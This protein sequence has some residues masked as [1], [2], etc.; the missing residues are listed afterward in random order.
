MPSTYTA[1]LRLTLPATGELSGLWGGTVNTGVTT[2]TDAAIAGYISV[3][4][5]DAD[6]TL[7]SVN[8]ATDQARY[9]MINMTGTLTGAKNVICPAA[10][11]VYLFKNS[12][13]GGFAITLKTPSGAGISVPN[14]KS[15][16]L[17]CDGTS[18]LD[19]VTHFNA[20]T[21]LSPT[22]TTPVLGTPSS[23]TLTSCTGLPIS[24][25]VS[26]LGTGVAT[27]LATP[28]TANLA[29]AVTGETGTGALVFGTSPA[30]TTPSLSAETYSTSATVTAGTNAQG[31]GALTSDYNV[32]TT[33]AA[34]PSGVTL[35]T[36]TV[37]R[38]VVIVNRGTNT[39]NVYPA[40]SAAIDG[41]AVN[42]AISIAVNGRVEFNAA[43]TT[44]WYSTVAVGTVS[45]T[46]V[47]TANGFVGSVANPTS[48]PAI[49]LS[50]NVTGV[51]KGN[52]TA[53]SAAVSGTDYFVPGTALSA[54]S[55]NGGQ[56][57]GLRNLIING[58]MR[59]AQRGT[60]GALTTAYTYLS[61]DRFAA[62]QSGTASGVFAQVAAGLSGFSYAAK[63]GRTAASSNL[64]NLSIRSALETVNS[65]SMQ[66]QQVTFSFYAKAGANYSAP[67]SSLVPL[68]YTSTGTDQSV[69]TF[70]SWTGAATPINT[71]TVITTSW[72]RYSFTGAIPS[73]TTQI[74]IAIIYQPTGTAGAD[75]NLYITGIQVEVGSVAT[76]FEN[77]PY[78]LS[79]GMCQR[80]YEKSFPTATAPAQNL[81]IAAS[82]AT[83]FIAGKA[84]ATAQFG[85]VKFSVTKRAAP[86]A[87]VFYNPSAAN[88]QVRDTTAGVDL[89]ATAS[90]NASESS[91]SI[92]ATGNASTA[93]GNALDVAW[94]SDSE[95]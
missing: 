22:L 9:M 46:S 34:N 41:L 82:G 74:G 60:S 84:G 66:G 32:I 61:I 70:N 51:I 19:A 83:R 85:H 20:L 67:S 12:T 48:T 77:I 80:Y 86:T 68:L 18:V 2:L 5:T 90:A 53:L 54:V 65:V 75:D 14:G 71:S 95:L 89:S 23:G 30:L 79:L 42:A 26:G 31:Q 36:A 76:P 88:A 50:T 94:T 37:G 17:M 43:T 28:T 69:D 13:T 24:T 57:G 92:T 78:N 11:K 6:Y 15:M 55:L 4:M 39:V 40:T 64:G 33:T 3:A 10:S 27:F 38:R 63:I 21:L 58:D 91:F 8:G 59:V 1:S 7:T 16:L 52:G 49:T 87:I 29:A 25:G 73:S 45:T 56:F 72:V 47:V 35:P 81:G 44:L 62:T 93:V